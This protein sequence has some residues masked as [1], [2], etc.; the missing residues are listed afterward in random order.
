M[1]FRYFK[2]GAWVDPNKVPT[3]GTA[4][5]V[6]VKQSGTDYD[7]A[8]AAGQLSPTPTGTNRFIEFLGTVGFGGANNPPQGTLNATAFYV[9]VASTLNRLSVSVTTAGSAGAVA[10]LGVYDN[11][12]D[13]APSELL[14]Q[15]TV[16]ASSTG[17]K[18]L[19]VSIAVS[20]GWYWFA[21][22][23]Q[24]LPASNPGFRVLS[25]GTSIFPTTVNLLGTV[26]SDARVSSFGDGVLPSTYPAFDTG[27]QV[28]NVAIR[29]TT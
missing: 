9:P 2:D 14:E 20:S 27:F 7:A 21:A 24:G 19:T 13:F 18:S 17:T 1:A 5:E 26:S 16:D 8:W 3:G 11:A 29:Y 28:H 12:A 23:S 25:P 4:G 10:R 6:L 15:G 22:V